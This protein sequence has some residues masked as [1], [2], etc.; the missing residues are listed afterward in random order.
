MTLRIEINRQEC[1]GSGRCCSL[2]PRVFEL[3]LRECAVVIDPNGDTDEH[4]AYVASQCPT[5]AINVYSGETKL[6]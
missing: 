4:I 3:D 5:H 2:A 1:I 6:A